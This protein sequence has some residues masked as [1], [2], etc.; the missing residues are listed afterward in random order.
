MK[1][2]ERFLHV[3]ALL[4]TALAGNV[5]G[6][7]RVA[8]GAP[9]GPAAAMPVPAS[10]VVPPPVATIDAVA[11]LSSV[12][13]G[14]DTLEARFTQTI[15]DGRGTLL[16]ESTGALWA[17]R[18]DRFRWEIDTPFAEL[19][20]G[21][22]ETLWLWDP[23]LEQV[24][25]R[26]YDERLRGT[27]ARLLSGRAADLVES[28]EVDMLRA[29]GGRDVFELR[30]RAGDGLFERLEMVFEGGAPRALVIHDSLG[31]RT[32]VRF[33]D[34]IVG[35]VVDPARFA[36]EIPEGADVLREEAEDAAGD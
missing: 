21:D 14:L 34:V 8:P 4:F 12:L 36:F 19:L 9:A 2:F 3:L 11:R 35:G 7:E 24:T 20:V 30:P 5:S 17:A 33:E 10:A 27:P 6:A 16:R 1:K 25:V 29:D 18:P 13:D 22:G 15:Q 23:D 26:P 31:Q 28:F 32:E